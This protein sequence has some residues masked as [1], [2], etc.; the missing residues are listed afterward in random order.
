MGPRR[1]TLTYSSE[2]AAPVAEQKVY[3]YYCK[4]SGKHAL[5]TDANLSEA[6]RRATDHALV[7]DTMKHTV[8]L[9][10]IDGGTKFI[11]RSGG[12]VEKQYRLSVGGLPFGYRT[13]PE[14]RYIYIFDDALTTYSAEEG[15]RIERAPVP[16]CIT[17]ANRIPPKTQIVLDLD[18][19]GKKPGIIKITADNV[20]LQLTQPVASPEAND[21]LLELLRSALGVRL[22]ALAITHGDSSRSKLLLVDGMRPEAAFTKL[23]AA[24]LPVRPRY[25]FHRGR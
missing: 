8:K 15:G 21:E 13:E 11:R 19:R 9:H 1:T 7:V 6:P 18:T 2:D 4:Y 23:K 17:Y 24:R 12:K 22:G 5:T 16:P 3:V 20:R 10:A 25:L 14:G